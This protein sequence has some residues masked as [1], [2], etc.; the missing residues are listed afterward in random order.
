MELSGW[1][2]ERLGTRT[3]GP[4]C[5]S[6]ANG[7]CGCWNLYPPP[8]SQAPHWVLIEDLE[9]EESNSLRCLQMRIQTQPSCSSFRRTWYLGI[10]FPKNIKWRCRHETLSSIALQFFDQACLQP[11]Q[12]HHGV[13]EWRGADHVIPLCLLAFCN[14]NSGAPQKPETCVWT[15]GS[16]LWVSGSAAFSWTSGEISIWL[17]RD[18]WN[19]TPYW[20]CSQLLGTFISFKSTKCL[21]YFEDMQLNCKSKFRTF[22]SFENKRFDCYDKCIAQD[23]NLTQYLSSMWTPCKEISMLSKEFM[24]C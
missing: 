3:N 6:R 15:L 21:L 9:C 16:S 1:C 19:M 11:P 14:S 7:S 22:K 17:F 18:V 5:P 2:W 24:L 10:H 13:E 20:H 23:K 4:R 8:P 12:S